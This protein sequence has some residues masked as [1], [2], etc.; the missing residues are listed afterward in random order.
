[1]KLHVIVVSFSGLLPILQFETEFLNMSSCTV[2]CTSRSYILCWLLGD[3][4]IYETMSQCTSLVYIITYIDYI[5]IFT[6]TGKS[7]QIFIFTV[8]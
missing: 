6:Y 2:K 7:R 3:N 5:N 8:S 4:Q 1:M